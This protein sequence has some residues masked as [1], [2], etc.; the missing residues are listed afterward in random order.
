[1]SDF[2][3]AE[4]RWLF[5]LA[6][7][8]YD[9]GRKIDWKRIA[10]NMKQTGKS[11]ESLRTRLKTLKKTHGKDLK[12][13]PLYFYQRLPVHVKSSK[14]ESK[15]KISNGKIQLSDFSTSHVVQA[16]E[17][18]MLLSSPK[19]QRT[20]RSPEC[21]YQ[22]LSEIFSSVEESEVHQ[23]SGKTHLNCG[24]ITAAGVSRILKAIGDIN[25]KD[26]FVDVGSGVGN[27][28]VQVALE[29][30]VWMC[31]GI[32]YRQDVVQVCRRLVRTSMSAYP[33]LSK[34]YVVAGDIRAPKWQS[35]VYLRT[36]TILFSS[37][38][39]FESV[40]NMQ[41]EKFV[42]CESQL[43]YVIVMKKF[44]HRHRS[45]CFREFCTIWELSM[46]VKVEV[47]WSSNL[48]DAYVYKK[49]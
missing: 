39:V 6:K 15:R 40:A 47:H 16:S 46:T 28:L 43:R 25:S 17:A 9:A 5:E 27:I 26:S 23:K 12:N 45:N 30:P 33:E 42:T 14:S 20:V 31:F 19:T 3:D 18:L 29:T 32:E 36:S 2:S 35:E 34:I 7:V 21:V 41:L 24:E 38:S 10:M 44:C 4:D 48:V 8:D 22:V 1:M 13:F 49:K 37:N 11:K